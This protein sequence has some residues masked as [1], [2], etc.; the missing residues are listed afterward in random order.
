[1][2]YVKKAFDVGGRSDSYGGDARLLVPDTASLSLLR[3][4]DVPLNFP[5]Y[6]FALRPPRSRRLCVGFIR[7]SFNCQQLA[8]LGEMTA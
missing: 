4:P 5:L 1:M 8:R 3:F 6:C 7:F 2:K